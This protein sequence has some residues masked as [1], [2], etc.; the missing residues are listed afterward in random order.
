MIAVDY[1]RARETM[2]DRQIR[3]ADVTD[4]RILSAVE[5]IPRE[6]FVPPPLRPLAYSDADLR[7]TKA[8]P[9]FLIEAGVFA[10]LVQLAAIGDEDIVL[11]VGCT[12]GYSSA[13]LARLANS[14]VALESDPELAATA[15][16]TLL[17][18][19]I[20]NAAVVTGPLEAGY[21]AEAPYDVILL[22]GSVELVPPSLTDQLKDGGRLVAVIGT[23]PAGMATVFQR[24]GDDISRRPAFNAPIPPLPDFERPRAFV[25]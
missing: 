16:E 21:P 24:T 12:T 8:E 3:T 25:F 23:G 14:V 13:V 11:D 7:L 6:I 4:R 22:G 1:A 20:G 19:D 18:L 17:G 15:T 9:R 2:V 5:Q 10:R